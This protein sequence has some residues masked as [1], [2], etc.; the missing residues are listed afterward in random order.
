[1]STATPPK[2]PE[3]VSSLVDEIERGSGGHRGN[4]GGEGFPWRKVRLVALGVIGAVGAGFI[5]MRFVGDRVPSPGDESRVRV[6]IDAET[7]EV[8]ERYRI[9]EGDTGPWKHPQTGRNTLYQ[10]EL[11]YWT[12][13]GEAKLEPTYVLLNEV[14]GKSGRTTC[15]DCGREVVAHNPLPPDALML[16]AIEAD[17]RRGR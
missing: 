5:A 10:P 13:D 2:R 4:S 14:A 16:E 1:M 17:K 6:M 8:F 11:C 3:S 12:A 15:P 7:G 9:R